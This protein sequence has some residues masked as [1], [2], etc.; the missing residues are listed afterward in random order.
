MGDTATV[1]VDAYLDRDFTG[2]VTEIAN[3]A[4]TLGTTTADQVTNF[5]VRIL[6]LRVRMRI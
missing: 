1:E 2:V 3:S 4:N 6:I 5:E